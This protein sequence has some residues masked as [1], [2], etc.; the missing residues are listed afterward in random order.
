MAT[1]LSYGQWNFL[2]FWLE[3]AWRF[4]EQDNAEAEQNTTA[5]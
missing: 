4:F 3:G 2:M 5:L 1:F